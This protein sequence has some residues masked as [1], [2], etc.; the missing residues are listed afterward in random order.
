MN[1]QP[2]LE[3]LSGEESPEQPELSLMLVIL[4]VDLSRGFLG[5]KYTFEDSDYC[6]VGS[7]ARS[8][9]ELDLNS[10]TNVVSGRLREN[11][12]VDSDGRVHLSLS[13]PFTALSFRNP[14]NSGQR[15]RELRVRGFWCPRVDPESHRAPTGEVA[16]VPP[17]RRHN[18]SSST[19]SSLID[20]SVIQRSSQR[21]TAG[22]SLPAQ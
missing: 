8:L 18:R 4:D 21:T 6:C 13:H 9:Q 20:S 14:A 17:E 19:F 1:F 22:S 15:R 5:V 12:T 2:R 11:L 3:H 16:K 7:A 10:S